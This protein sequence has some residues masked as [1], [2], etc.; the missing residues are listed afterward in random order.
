MPNGVCFH[1]PARRDPCAGEGECVTCPNFVIAAMHLP[2]HELRVK[3]L[4]AEL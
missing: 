2:V 1:H 3:G 4:E